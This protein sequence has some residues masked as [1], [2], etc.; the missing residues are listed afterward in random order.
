[1]TFKAILAVLILALGCKGGTTSISHNQ[2]QQVNIGGT[3]C[4]IEEFLN[5]PKEEV[6]QFCQQDPETIVGFRSP[7]CLECPEMAQC[8][9]GP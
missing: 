8:L 2:N 5:C 1:M 4:T 7:T 6:R 3:K 9:S